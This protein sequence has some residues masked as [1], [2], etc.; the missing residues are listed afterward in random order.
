MPIPLLS[1][2]PYL[3]IQFLQHHIDLVQLSS[4]FIGEETE[5][6]MGR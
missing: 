5:A 6:E 2:Y 3:F 1:G 4:Y